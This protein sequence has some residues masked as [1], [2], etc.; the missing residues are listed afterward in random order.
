MPDDPAK[1]TTDDKEFLVK[2]Q[3]IVETW[4]REAAH[5]G[6][7]GALIDLYEDR[8]GA[9]PDDVRAVIEDTHDEAMLRAWTRLA[10]TQGVD[11]VV[12]AIRKARRN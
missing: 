9:M 10:A 11:E 8:F 1:Q 7:V 4:R 12:A 2:T 3:D 5:E 6:R